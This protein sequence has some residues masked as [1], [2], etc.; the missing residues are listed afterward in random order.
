MDVNVMWDN[1]IKIGVSEETLNV[2]TRING[3]SQETMYNILFAVTGYNNFSQMK[4]DP[5]YDGMCIIY[6]DDEEE[7]EGEE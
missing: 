7:E 5:S 4:T 3:F 2:V 1:L 6:E